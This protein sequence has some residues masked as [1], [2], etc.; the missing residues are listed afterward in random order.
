MEYRK[1]EIIED[2]SGKK[3]LKLLSSNGYLSNSNH[4]GGKKARKTRKF[5]K[6]YMWNTK[7]KRYMAKTYKQHLRG[8]KLGHTHKKPKTRKY[9]KEKK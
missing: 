4:E 7:G 8:V 1:Y 9:K 3:K 6:H 5:K 2:N